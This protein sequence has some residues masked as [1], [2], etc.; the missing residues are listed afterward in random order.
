[1]P[2]QI[3]IFLVDGTPTGLR[4]A[5]L[6]LSTCK[7][8]M[9]PRSQLAELQRREEASR[10]GVYLLVGPDN[11]DARRDALYIGEGD[12][13][14]KR[15]R[16]HDNNDDM[17]FWVQVALF[18]SKDDN[19]T[20][21]HVRFLEARLVQM[22]DEA[23]QAVVVNHQRPVGGQL[24]EAD[25][26][27]MEELIEHIVLLAGT[28]GIHGFRSSRQVSARPGAEQP[29][30]GLRLHYSGR[31]WDA[32]SV[33]RDGEFLVLAGSTARLDEANSL[34]DSSRAKRAALIADGVLVHDGV[35]LRFTQDHVFNSASG[36]ATAVAGGTVNGKRAWKLDDGRTFDEW[37]QSQFVETDVDEESE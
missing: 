30:P 34:I 11:Q 8:V 33:F 28:L 24:P 5:E 7:A 6:G 15:I 22:A 16:A 37:E 19:L 31:G 23:K 29:E 2:K 10:T 35:S 14:F 25:R 20:K 21:A 3:K 18:V 27:E 17:E 12:N 13:V 9:A 26:A 32:H 36:A 1:M 4:T